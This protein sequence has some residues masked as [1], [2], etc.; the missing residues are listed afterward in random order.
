MMIMYL[1]NNHEK[2]CLF[3]TRNSFEIYGSRSSERPWRKTK[4]NLEDLAG[5]TVLEGGWTAGCFTEVLLG[6][7]TRVITLVM[8]A[9]ARMAR[10][11]NAEKGPLLVF[12][13]DILAPLW[14]RAASDTFSVMA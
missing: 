9:A 13:I 10:D 4:W 6:A 7:S 1:L 14:L 12:G 2:G 11:Q 5:R 3:V 8:S